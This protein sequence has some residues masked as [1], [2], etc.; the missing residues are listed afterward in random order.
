MGTKIT[1]AAVGGAI[2]QQL[3]NAGSLSQGSIQKFVDG[4]TDAC[5]GFGAACMAALEKSAQTGVAISVCNIIEPCESTPNCLDAVQ[6]SI[7]PNG[8]IRC[9]RWHMG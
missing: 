9:L 2:I 6:I 5:A 7:L 1:P 4:G 8:G 3:I